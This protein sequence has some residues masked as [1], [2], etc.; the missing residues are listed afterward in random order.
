MISKKVRFWKATD[1]KMI[2][3]MVFCSVILV[4]DYVVVISIIQASLFFNSFLFGYGRRQRI[5]MP[6]LWPS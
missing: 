6:N 4:Y 3:A 5:Y 2:D 1:A